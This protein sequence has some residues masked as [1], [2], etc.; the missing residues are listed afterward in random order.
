M[1]SLRRR[2]DCRQFTELVTDY[3]E[4]ALSPADRLLVD[5]HLEACPNCPK[6]RDQMR[7]TIRL[8]GAL[9]DRVV[10]DDVLDALQR[11]WAEREE[12]ER[13]NG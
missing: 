9:Q 1:I 8:A 3:F 6:Y 10:P 2:L 7:A 11:A 13:D 5:R 4:G 12:G